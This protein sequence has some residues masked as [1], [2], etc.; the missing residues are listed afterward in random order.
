MHEV[1]IALN[2]IDIV[3]DQCRKSG[4]TKIDAVNVKIGK[5]SGVMTDALIFAFDAVKKDSM[6]KGASLKIVEVPVSGTCGECDK[7]FSVNEKY[8]LFCPVC[9]SKSFCVTGGREMDIIDIE[10]S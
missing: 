10:V 5:A 9:G 6:A 7:S 8:V 2:M 3:S 1:S 4:F